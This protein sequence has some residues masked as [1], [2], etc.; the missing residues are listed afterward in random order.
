MDERINFFFSEIAKSEDVH[1][2]RDSLICYDSGAVVMA[3][4]GMERFLFTTGNAPLI[5]ALNGTYTEGVKKCPCDHANRLVINKHLDYTKPQA[6]GVEQSTFGFGDRLGVMTPAHIMSLRDYSVKPI[7]A[8]Q[9]KREMSLTNRTL[10]DVLD[11]VVYGVLQTGYKGGFGAD[12]DHLKEAEDVEKALDL[13]FSMI[14]IDCSN[15]LCSKNSKRTISESLK[16]EYRSHKTMLESLGVGDSRL[17][18]QEIYSIYSDALDFI[19]DIYNKQ[20]KERPMQIDFEVSLDE[21]AEVTSPLGHFFVAN[22]LRKREVQITSLAPRFVGKFE[23][24]IDYIGDADDFRNDLR[25]H[26]NI[27]KHFGYKISLHSGSDKFSIFPAF[28]DEKRVC[29]HVK[30]SGTSWLEAL[31]VIAV[32]NPHLFKDVFNISVQAFKNAK[33]Y[34]DVGA[35][36]ERID[37]IEK[38][39]PASYFK[40]LDDRHARQC[41]HIGYGYVLA[42]ADI[43]SRIYRTLIQNESYF[44]ETAS[45]HLVRHLEMLE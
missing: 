12:A 23:K 2:Y 14:T 30:T 26:C 29:F 20:I 3:R 42:D 15:V 39:D 32:K 18:L 34:Y 8:Q 4:I 19:E 31:R 38:K 37:P 13:G 22:E 17:S 41:L 9:S 36:L 24:G 27:A 21:T 33:A 45:K 5:E 1:I 16:D 35:E 7:L 6:Y 43:K 28:S 25:V 44:Y 10:D 40:Y 11:D